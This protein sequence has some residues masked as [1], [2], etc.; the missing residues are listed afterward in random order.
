[1]QDASLSTAIYVILLSAVAFMY[2]RIRA[3][4]AKVEMITSATLDIG[5]IKDD[6]EDLKGTV[7]SMQ[8]VEPEPESN[9]K[10]VDDDSDDES[11]DED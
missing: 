1:M 2:S 3:I 4:E 5:T 11:S 9:L 7:E 6:I 10:P 8:H